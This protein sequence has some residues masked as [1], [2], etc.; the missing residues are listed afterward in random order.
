[1]NTNNAPFPGV[2][3]DTPDDAALDALAERLLKDLTK[4]A[5]LSQAASAGMPTTAQEIKKLF[6]EEVPDCASAPHTPDSSGSPFHGRDAATTAG[7]QFFTETSFDVAGIRRDFPA[8]QQHINGHNLIWFD[9]AATTQKPRRV[10][11]T[12]KGYYERDNSNIHRGAHTLAR[13]ATD[14]YE[15][16]REAIQRFIGAGSKEEIIFLRGTTEAIN[17]VAQSYGRQYVGEGDEI[18]VTE[19]EHHSNIVPWQMLAREK[20][21]L[22]KVI[23]VGDNGEILLDA[24]ERLLG[25][26]TKIVAIGHVSNAIGAIAPVETMIAQARRYNAKVLVDGAQAVSHFRVN[27]QTMQ[28][29]FYVFSGHKLFGPTGIGVLYGKAELL[30]DMPPWQGGGNMIK[31]VTWEQTVYNDIPQKF[32]AGTNNIAGAIGLGAAIDYLNSLNFDRLSA[33][34]QAL[35]SHAIQALSTVKGLRHIGNAPHK[36]GALSFV[37]DGIG[38][39]EIGRY[40][41]Q[42]GI[43]VRAGHHC[44]QP[45][46]ARFNVSGTVRPSLAFYNT[47]EE[48]DLLVY[49]LKRMLN[50]RSNALAFEF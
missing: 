34:E 16:A 17:L 44:A 39:E 25:P 47:H 8:L 49:A 4:N 1:M 21:A 45:T 26:K 9:N 12:L 31:S 5:G 32:E 20:R 11:E 35:M 50:R 33:H 23:P 18:L 28:P 37:I 19:L 13:K 29:D 15:A 24:Y 3:P 46:M 6:S 27:M 38:P 48:I 42:E 36:I 30:R 41:D 43:A 40:L 10:I 2:H 22:L 14:R 7:R